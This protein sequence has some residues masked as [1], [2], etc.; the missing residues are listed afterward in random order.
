MADLCASFLVVLGVAWVVRRGMHG[1]AGQPLSAVG[2]RR[3]VFFSLLGSL[4][5]LGV[6]AVTGLLAWGVLVVPASL[7]GAWLV[8][9]R[10]MVRPHPDPKRG[11]QSRSGATAL[12][13]RFSPAPLALTCASVVACWVAVNPTGDRP[14]GQVAAANAAREPEVV[15]RALG[16]QIAPAAS[17]RVQPP[18]RAV[19]AATKKPRRPGS[20][21]MATRGAIIYVGN[22]GQLTANTG[23]T[24]ASGTVAQGV[25]D[26]DL[27]SGRF[28]RRRDRQA[29]T[30]SGAGND[31][32]TGVDCAA[33]HDSAAG[34]DR[35]AGHDGAAGHDRAARHDRSSPRLRHQLDTRAFPSRQRHPRGARQAGEGSQRHC[36]QRS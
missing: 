28:L 34:H 18:A 9:C 31:S 14:D 20:V 29:G 2:R 26:S 19:T 15:S 36:A 30:D 24:S 16:E 6:L 21:V 35:R 5:V 25:E 11:G 8:L 12:A 22:N 17:A 27:R 7:L 1:T 4:P 13:G 33:G 3:W 32:E 10:R 23:P